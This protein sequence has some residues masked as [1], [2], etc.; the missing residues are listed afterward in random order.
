M[1]A[2]VIPALLKRNRLVLAVLA[3]GAA[4]GCQSLHDA[5]VPGM[6]AFLNSETQSKEE[7]RHRT[8]YQTSR[9]PSEMRWLLRNKVY[10]GMSPSEVSKIIGDEGE[11]VYD[12]GWVK[13][14]GGYYQA[15]D[16]VWKWGPD[17]K[18]QSVMLVFREN[19]LLNFDP[20]EFEDTP[21]F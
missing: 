12:D 19:E 9:D 4:S 10:S 11:R 15:S 7:E 18:G 21:E 16:E 3:V 6:A 14:E 2:S 1:L 17:R 13:N 20:T 8:S 5:G